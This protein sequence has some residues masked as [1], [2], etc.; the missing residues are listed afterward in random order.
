MYIGSGFEGLGYTGL[1]SLGVQGL[2]GPLRTSHFHCPSIDEGANLG[3]TFWVQLTS[4][5]KTCPFRAGET[6]SFPHVASGTEI[7][8]LAPRA[9]RSRSHTRGSSTR[10]LVHCMES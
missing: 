8:S 10:E 2:A 9:E 7:E 3:R 5:G 4:T 6:R 1:K